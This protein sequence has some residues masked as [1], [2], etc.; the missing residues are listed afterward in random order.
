[1][2]RTSGSSSVLELELA[3]PESQVVSPKSTT[4][5]PT[6]ATSPQDSDTVPPIPLLQLLNHHHRPIDQRDFKTHS[7]SYVFW[8]Y[9]SHTLRIMFF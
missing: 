3:Q 8:I 4:L 2:I 9:Y 1:M 5:V 7:F 6:L